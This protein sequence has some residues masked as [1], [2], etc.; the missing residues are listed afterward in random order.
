[1]NTDTQLNKIELS[2]YIIAKTN[3]KAF[4]LL[5]GIICGLFQTPKEINGDNDTYIDMILGTI[6]NSNNVSEAIESY[7]YI[8]NRSGLDV[9]Y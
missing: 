2:L 6:S 5:C 8:I 4:S 3:T 9:A 1:M 7:Y